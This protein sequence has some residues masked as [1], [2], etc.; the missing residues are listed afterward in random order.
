MDEF[1]A[2]GRMSELMEEIPVYMIKHDAIGLL[3]LESHAKK[4]LGV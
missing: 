3:G 2:K 1:K 4:L